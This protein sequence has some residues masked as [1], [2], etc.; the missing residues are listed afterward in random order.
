M[1]EHDQNV[2]F[3]MLI[4]TKI[5][6]LSSISGMDHMNPLIFR[7]SL[8]FGTEKALFQGYFS[9]HVNI[10]HGGI[11]KSQSQVVGLAFVALEFIFESYL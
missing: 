10:C 2:L 4:F 1:T 5:I 3:Y 8:K 6:D 11:N 9:D 7:H